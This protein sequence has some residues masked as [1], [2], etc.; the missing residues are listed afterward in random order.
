MYDFFY[1]NPRL[2]ILTIALILVS[3]FFSY[4]VLP[5]MEDPQLTQR[6]AMITTVFPGADAARVEALVTDIIEDELRE[7][8]EIKELRSFSQTGISIINIELRDDVYEVANVWSRVRDKLSDA[9]PLLPKDALEPEFEDID[10]K[11]YATLVALQ[12]NGNGEPNYAIL[13]R[14]S[15]NLKDELM[16]LS[17]TEEVDLFGDPQEEILVEIQ[18]EKLA[19][20]GLTGQEVAGQIGNSDSKVSAGL[21][22]GEKSDILLEVK[23]ELDSLSRIESIP[24]QHGDEQW[25]PLHQVAD[26][27]KGIRQPP[28]SL[29]VVSGKPAIVLGLKVR[30]SYRID[31]WTEQV[32][33]KLANFNDRL[34]HGIEQTTIF[35]QNTYVSNRLQ[36]LLMNLLI[37]AGAVV[38][39][40]FVLMG[41]RN[42][43]IVGLSLPLSALMVLSGLRFLEIP[44]HQM[45]VTGLIVAL[46]LLIDNAIVMVD[47]VGEE[48]SN[49]KTPLEA[50]GHS[51]KKLAIPLLGST[52]TTALAFAPIALMPGPAGEFVG[53]IAVSVILAIF[54]SLFLALTI[55]PTVAAVGRGMNSVKKTFLNN[56]VQSPRLTNIYRAGLNWL[57]ARPVVGLMACA[58]LPVLGFLA[59][60]QLPE[61]FFPP[62]D[63]DQF[64][65][66]VELDPQASLQETQRLVEQVRRKAQSYEQVQEVHWFLGESAPSFY[67]NVVPKKKNNSRYAQGIVQLTSATKSRE[68]IHQLQDE[69][70]KSFPGTRILV[71]QLEQGPPFDAPVEVRIYGP[72]VRVLQNLSRDIRLVLSEIPDVT[73]TRSDL[74]EVQPKEYLVVDEEETRMFGLDHTSVALQ[75]QAKLEGAVGGS[76]LEDTEELPVRVRVSGKQRGSK[77]SV[78]S[79]DLIPAK[80]LR[81]R[82]HPGVPVSAVSESELVSEISS[83]TRLDSRRLSEVQAFVKAGVLPATVLTAFKDRVAAGDITLPPGYTIEYG[84]EAAERDN[85]VGNLMANVGVLLVLMVATLVLSFRS[86]RAAS[87]IGVIAVL[88]AGFGL[89]ALWVFGYP[90]GF[91]AIIGT[92]GLIG[93]AIN[94]AIVVLVALRED[95]KARIGDLQAVTDVVVRS[96]RHVIATS[97]TTMVGFL[98][99]VL[100]GGGFWPP[101]AVAISGGVGGATLLGLLFVP[102]AFVLMARLLRKPNAASITT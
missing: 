96:S 52:I 53:S 13:R 58:V 60:T 29:A 80:P 7:V 59:A 16:A 62:T 102:S 66:E 33:E 90:F 1:R 67:Y 82:T 99:L 24:V 2:T 95:E 48:L 42:A 34:P 20:L 83:V 85:A 23:G 37:G 27:K 79:L 19:A 46:G 94:D 63:R 56:G 73:H 51:V 15:E 21:F 8:E 57:F 78:D 76:V 18:P 5:R 74:E 100:A 70:D 75:L 14:L 40:V 41:W 72:D 91:M 98:P 92:M 88:S 49:G 101:L 81:T 61:Q 69:L 44:I 28:E 31:L 22:R 6:V 97:I 10:V 71:R 55:V 89:G 35:E 45:S 17:G 86:F 64:H 43:F 84:G 38:V 25:V 93:V 30:G 65:I 12:W 39:V 87:L 11:A 77:S 50:V 68:L 32:R 26:V 54:S 36:D 4:Q 3:G 47:E 9:E